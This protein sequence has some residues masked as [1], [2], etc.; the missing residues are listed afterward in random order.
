MN[1]EKASGNKMLKDVVKNSNTT[2]ST[3]EITELSMDLID[4]NP[5]NEKVFSMEEIDVLAKTIEQEG[6]IGAIEVLKMPNDRYEISSGHRRYRA[7]KTLGRKTIPCVINRYIDDRAT[8]R[9]LLSSN[10][11]NRIMSAIDWGNAI[12][13]YMENVAENR[14][15]NA[16]S[17]KE[18]AEF[19]NFSPTKM[20]RLLSLT[21]LIP[22]LQE[23]ATHENFPF[24]ALATAAKL[25]EAKQK[26]LA[27]FIKNGLEQSEEE[28]IP[29]ISKTVLSKKI[30]ALRGTERNKPV[31]Q[32]SD[33]IHSAPTP[34]LSPTSPAR[35]V[36]LDMAE[37][38]N[39]ETYNKVDREDTVTFEPA[40]VSLS[41][42]SRES[43]E[44]PVKEF[45]EFT[46]S[47]SSEDLTDDMKN[48]LKQIRE[49]IDKLLK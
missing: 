33:I 48:D 13:Y 8:A 16:S 7:M 36:Y 38:R 12:R 9:R 31:A 17:R 24:N 47:L 19:F 26:E 3:V 21:E 1:F 22:E 20:S 43:K 28:D 29:T 34:I 39:S 2:N 18:C 6:F 40:D 5:D 32:R 27:E 14:G 10:I 4:E 42:V 45:L 37:E 15:I 23:Y 49:C 46:F 30:I 44:R 35:N 11:R 25:N 41:D